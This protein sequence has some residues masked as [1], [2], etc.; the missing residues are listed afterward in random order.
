M[1]MINEQCGD[2]GVKQ[3]P[4]RRYKNIKANIESGMA[5]W[6]LYESTVISHDC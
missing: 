2:K 5:V 4:E 6:A 1:T 3:C